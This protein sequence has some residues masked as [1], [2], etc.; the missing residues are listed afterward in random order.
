VFL[1]PP[2]RWFLEKSK[3][4]ALRRRIAEI[5]EGAAFCPDGL[6]VLRYPTGMDPG[7]PK[8]PI[9]KRTYGESTVLFLAK[10]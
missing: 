6:L 9:D 4:E 8:S 1:D 7:V 10:G 5:L 3:V 2:F